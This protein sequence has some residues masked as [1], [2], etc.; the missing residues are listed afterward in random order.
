MKNSIEIKDNIHT[1]IDKI[2]N[3]ELLEIF[4]EPLNSRVWK[5][6]GQLLEDLT[7][8]QKKELYEAYDESIDESTLINLKDLKVKHFKW[9]GK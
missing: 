1:L 8:E 5:R 2:D 3:R 7:P 9:F 4:Y 6:E